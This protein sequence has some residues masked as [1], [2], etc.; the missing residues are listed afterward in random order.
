MTDPKSYA[1]YF[2]RQ[3]VEHPKSNRAKRKVLSRVRTLP[4]EEAPTQFTMG[5][6]ANVIRNAEPSK[7]FCPD[8]ISMVL[9]KQ[10]HTTGIECLTKVPNLSLATHIIS[11]ALKMGRV[12]PLLKPGKDASKY[13]SYRPISLLSPVSKARQNLL[14]T[15]IKESS[16]VANN[17][18]GFRP[19]QHC[20]PYPQISVEDKIRTSP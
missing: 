5:D 4:D 8:G 15:G 16:P 14:L 17:Q 11:E 2:S 3:F 19:Q 12:V 10:L 1:V 6:V 7:A 9:L 13:E 20:T 18:H